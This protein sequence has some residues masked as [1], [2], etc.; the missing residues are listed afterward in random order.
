MYIN[1]SIAEVFLDKISQDMRTLKEIKRLQKV[2]KNQPDRLNG[3]LVSV[4]E[5][6]VY[7]DTL[8]VNNERFSRNYT[9]LQSLVPLEKATFVKPYELRRD[10]MTQND[11]NK[12]LKEGLVRQQDGLVAWEDYELLLSYLNFFADLVELGIAKIAEAKTETWLI[13]PLNSMSSSKLKN[14]AKIVDEIASNYFDR[15]FD[16]ISK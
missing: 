9:Y 16:K 10:G 12:V 14:T 7:E 2:R 1:P 8:S 4:A 6:A 13:A 5:R 3:S 15:F 11:V